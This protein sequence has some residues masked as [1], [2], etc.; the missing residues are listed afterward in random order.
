MEGGHEGGIQ[1]SERQA[2]S[3]PGLP[4]E[5]EPEARRG[6]VFRKH[7]RQPMKHVS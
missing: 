2:E 7:F 6:A 5:S 1:R 4:S 3:M